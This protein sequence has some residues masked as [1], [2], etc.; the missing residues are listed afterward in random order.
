MCFSMHCRSEAPSRTNAFMGHHNK[1]GCML[2]SD[3]ECC[4][5]AIASLMKYLHAWLG[6]DMQ[7]AQS[8]YVAAQVGQALSALF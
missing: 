7:D 4:Y 3:G 2:P 6:V 5:A 8:P 1:V